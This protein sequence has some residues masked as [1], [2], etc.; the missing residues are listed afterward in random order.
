MTGQQPPSDPP[1][2]PPP[3]PPPNYQPP[4]P[5]PPGYYPYFNPQPAKARGSPAAIV[6]V[7]VGALV[8][9]GL[10]VGIIVLFNQPPPP[11]PPCDPG[12]LCGSP[13]TPRPVSNRTPAPGA[14][15][16]PRTPGPTA[17]P[18]P[19]ATLVATGAPHPTAIPGGG[20]T[21]APTAVST[22]EAVTLGGSWT[23]SAFGVGFE[24]NP[25][26]FT[27]GSNG[28]DFAILNDK[29]FDASVIVKATSGETTPAEYIEEQVGVLDT[30]MIARTRDTDDYD[31][32]LGPSIGYVNGE[33]DVYSGILLGPNGT[34][35]A[36][37]GATI[38]AATNGQ[39]TVAVIV[40]VAQPDL[41]F[42]IDSV[43]HLVRST[44]DD[45]LKT[46]NWGTP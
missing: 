11:V 29:F 22:A 36:P 43:Q 39:V 5:P 19:V 27:M 37:G 35:T 15:P 26:Y 20:P 34:P 4:P 38:L 8:A 40:I 1:A 32:V 14:T 31:A 16:A 18:E 25:D 41:L 21:P 2:A 12:V 7:F 30:T 44:A 10:V 28:A 17:T 33:A 9:V 23:S 24:F 3:G 46:F 13:P 42:G 6:A 45:V